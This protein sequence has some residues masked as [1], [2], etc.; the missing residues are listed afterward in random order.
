MMHPNKTY[1]LK[2]YDE[3]L[4][5]FQASTDSYGAIEYRLIEMDDARRHL[6]PLALIESIDAKGLSDWLEARIIPKNRK[7]IEAILIAAGLSM[8]DTL[9]VIE[10]S[11]AL[12]VNDS[13][14]VVEQGSR[15]SY[16]ECN[17][18]DNPTNEW[19]A[20]IAYTGDIEP[21]K[22]DVLRL[23]TEWTTQGTF[24]KAWR[25]I[26]GELILY[27]GGTEGYA[28]AGMEPY[29]E[30]LASQLADA[31]GFDHVAYE[32]DEWEG[33]L[34]ST[35]VLMN[36]KDVSFVSFMAAT[37]QYDFPQNVA[38]CLTVDPRCVK[39]LRELML[40]DAIIANRDRHA[41]NYGFLRDNRTGE[42]LGLAP[43]FD[44]N[45]AL[46]AHDMESDFPTWNAK[47]KVQNPWM[48]NLSFDEHIAS[49]V[50]EDMLQAV[51][52]ARDF[53][54]VNHPLFPMPSKRLD[55]LNA[56]ISSRLEFVGTLQPIDE[57]AFEKDMR[58]ALDAIRATGKGIPADSLK[59]ILRQ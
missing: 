37:K 16:A 35:C 43:I 54:F 47:V 32:L 58:K 13:F 56:Y 44:N 6:F 26:Q 49:I 42:I 39:R 48:T 12:S 38:A 50:D 22:A 11:K 41:G 21:S 28:N 5:S 14:W 27:K 1:D 30:Y 3:I 40:F 46:F 18:Y 20:L 34:A 8:G 9:G 52:S 15:L 31:L 53:E 33:R 59:S 45:V 2:L 51:R 25:N 57:S 36:S 17:L 55:A 7:N 4:L 23:S 19:L 10:V 24:P 29:S